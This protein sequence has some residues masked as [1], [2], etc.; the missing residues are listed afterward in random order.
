MVCEL[1]DFVTSHRRGW[2]TEHLLISVD[3]QHSKSSPHQASV[4]FSFLSYITSQTSTTRLY[5]S[6]SGQQQINPL[7]Q[8]RYRNFKMNTEYIPP[9]LPPPFALTTP[10]PTLLA[11]GAEARLYKTTFLTPDTPAALKIRSTKPYRHELLDRRLT[12]QRVLHEARCLMKLLREGVSVPAVLALDWDPATPADG[13]RSVGAWLLMEWIDGLALKH[14]LERWEKW[15]KKSINN[16]TEGFN[17][18]EE[19]AKVKELMKKIGRTVGSMHKVGVVHGDL[20][21]SNMIL[22]PVDSTPTGITESPTMTGDIVLIDFGLAS[23][24]SAE[25]DRAV[26]LYVLERAFGSTHP[27]TEDFFSEILDGY[28]ESF[29]GAKM[30]LRKLEDVRMRGRKRSMLG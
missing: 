27:M 12:R 22:R 21:T 6:T 15:M 16:P 26:D 20:T 19:E 3:D 18:E 9:P 8:K 17:K 24:S 30:V 23:T 5:P 2:T 11:Q 4:I 14:I 1:N 29:K 25:E 7:L 13:T 10:P 28:A